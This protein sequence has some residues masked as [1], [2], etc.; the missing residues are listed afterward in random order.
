MLGGFC[1][2]WKYTREISDLNVIKPQWGLFIV[3][4]NISGMHLTQRLKLDCC[5]KIFN[6]SSYLLC[7]KLNICIHWDGK[8]VND[9]Y[10]NYL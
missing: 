6:S 4:L 5:F 7:W 3:I 10:Q 9:L 1:I 2:K 8:K